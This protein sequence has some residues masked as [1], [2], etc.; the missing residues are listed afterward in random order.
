ME[1]RNG[2]GIGLSCWPARLYTQPGVIGSSIIGLLKVYK[3]E[4]WVSLQLIIQTVHI[5]QL[6][7][8]V[9]D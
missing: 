9:T 3:F 4:L 5:L 2:V 1:A 8:A 6:D 7:G